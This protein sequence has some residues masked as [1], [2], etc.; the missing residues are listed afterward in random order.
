MFCQ[1]HSDHCILHLA[2]LSVSVALNTTTLA[3]RD[4][5]WGG[6]QPFHLV[7]LLHHGALRYGGVCHTRGEIEARWNLK[8]STQNQES[9]CFHGLMAIVRFSGLNRTQTLCAGVVERYTQATYN[10]AFCS[11]NCNIYLGLLCL[12]SPSAIHKPYKPD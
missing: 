8:S 9:F 1:I 11:G 12:C 2:V 6:R 10:P 3:H 4:A 7:P 5:V